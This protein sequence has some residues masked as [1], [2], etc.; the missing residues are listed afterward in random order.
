MTTSIRKKYK[1]DDSYSYLQTDTW[2]SHLWKGIFL[3]FMNISDS[4]LA[5]SLDGF[6]FDLFYSPQNESL[7]FNLHAYF[8]RLII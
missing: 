8:K 5:P 3:H 6:V 7:A 2:K 1:N 4:F